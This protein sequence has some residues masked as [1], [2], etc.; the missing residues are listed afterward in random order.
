VLTYAG[1]RPQLAAAH[2]ALLEYRARFGVQP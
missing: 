1:D 2:A